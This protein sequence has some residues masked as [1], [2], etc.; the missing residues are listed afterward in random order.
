MGSAAAKQ[1]HSVSHCRASLSADA[2]RTTSDMDGW[3]A[4]RHVLPTGSP[5]T[6]GVQLP[7]LPAKANKGDDADA[8]RTHG[9][10]TESNPGVVDAGGVRCHLSGVEP[11]EHR[12]PD[13]SEGETCSEEKSEQ[14]TNALRGLQPMLGVSDS[15]K[16]GAA[17]LVHPSQVSLLQALCQLKGSRWVLGRRWG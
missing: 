7:Q 12:R 16:R 9:C 17:S 1:A 13:G 3:S 5:S 10:E 8:P 6:V 2:S 15:T 14:D 11:E 4:P